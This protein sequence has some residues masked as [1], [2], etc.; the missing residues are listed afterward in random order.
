MAA[1]GPAR[2]PGE[3]SP[4]QTLEDAASNSLDGA[5]R[6]HGLG[7]F[8]VRIRRDGATGE[9]YIAGMPPRERREN[10]ESKPKR[11][12]RERRGEK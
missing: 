9:V 12:P 11:K 8:Q 6:R 1:P 3:R 7:S 4:L 5:R 2:R 10:A